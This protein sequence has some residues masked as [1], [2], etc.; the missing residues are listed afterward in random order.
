M[1]VL[2]IDPSWGHDAKAWIDMANGDDHRSN[3][4]NSLKQ[5]SNG[6]TC[7]NLSDCH[8]TDAKQLADGSWT[9]VIEDPGGKRWTAIPPD[10]VV[11]RPLSIDGAAYLCNAVY[12]I[13]D[14]Y[15]FIPPIPGY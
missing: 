11:K 10:K 12:V 3:W 9:A 15:C 14:I 8:E 6:I 5:P 1:T 2:L 13:N 7:C 4:F